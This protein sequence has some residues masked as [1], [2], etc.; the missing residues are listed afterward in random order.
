MKFDDKFP[1]GGGHDLHGTHI[2][3]HE[4]A[5]PCAFCQQPTSWL[6]DLFLAPLCSEE[7][8]RETW[9]SYAAHQ[10]KEFHFNLYR[11]QIVEELKLATEV[12]DRP[13]DIIIVVHDQLE[14]LKIC[15][16]SIRATTQNYHLYIW[17]NN[18]KPET[19]K[20]LEEVMFAGFADVMRSDTNVGF[21]QPNNELV[22]WGTGEYVILLN[23]DVKVFEGWDTAMLSFLQHHPE[24]AQVGY[25]GGLLDA[26]GE[27]GRAVWG[28]DCDYIMGFCTCFHRQTYNEFGL[29]NP[30][31][32]FAY[33][34]DSDFSMRL[35]Q[36]GKKL[37]ALHCMLVHHYENK[38]IKV[39]K[40]EGEVDVRAT[41]EHNHEW[42]RNNW[43]SYLENNRVDVRKDSTNGL[44]Q[45]VPG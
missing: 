40:D 17:D 33:C 32:K 35:Q 16:D 12:I 42:I 39:V 13:K 27:G 44:V 21:I 36:A 30:E 34:E 2:T 45:P 4:A 8:S 6:D 41:F 18:S 7:C 26:K 22:K 23:S 19:Q 37:Y 43:K 1:E 15:I 11:T 14:Y 9:A 25:I 31:L 10:R 38:T 28:Y 5:R 24:V 29:F 20:Y 3:K